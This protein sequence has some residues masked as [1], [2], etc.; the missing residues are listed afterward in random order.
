MSTKQSGVSFWGRHIHLRHWLIGISVVLIVLVGLGLLAS[1]K[2]VWRQHRLAPF[3]ET[4]GLSAEG[5]LG[6]IVRSEPMD[7]PVEGGTATRVLYRTQLANGSPAFSSGMIFVPDTPAPVE[8]RPVVAWAHGTL[9]LGDKCAPTR[10]KNPLQGVEWVSDMLRNGWVVAATDYAGLGTPGT[11]AYLIGQ[12]EAHDVLNS[13][14]AARNMPGTQAGTAFTVWGHSQGGHSALFTAQMAAQYAPELSLKGTVASAPAAEL[15]AMVSAGQNN[16][17]DWVIGPQLLLAWP[18][19]DP[20]LSPEQVASKVGLRAY[21]KVAEQCIEGAT[22]GGLVRNGL[23]QT[24][25]A[26]NPSEVPAWSAELAAQTA[27]VLSPEQPLLVA[28]STTD[29]VILPGGTARYIQRACE[30]GGNVATLWI[31]DT[32]HMA[33]PKVIAPEVI[34]WLN[35]RFAGLANATDCQEQL[36]VTPL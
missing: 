21:H 35:D 36:P 20:A 5:P 32:T 24:F 23:H 34:T 18:G 11:Q 19:V 13:V 26:T 29:N 9:G 22:L 16:V 30:G 17:L 6:E 3:Y 15:S 12:A 7:L 1:G 31:G 27:P 33:I 4:A 14:R 28:E 2:N 10:A 25:F 8:G